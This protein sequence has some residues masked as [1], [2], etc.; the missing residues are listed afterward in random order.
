LPDRRAVLTSFRGL[1]TYVVPKVDVRWRDVAND[2][3]RNQANYVVSECHR[4]QRTRPLGRNLSSGN[5][6]VNLIPQ[7]TL[8]SDRRNNIDF[9]AAKILR[10]GQMHAV[11]STCHNIEQRCIGL[12][13]GLRG[14]DRDSG[15]RLT[16]S[17][18]PPRGS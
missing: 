15:E 11:G 16:P 1:A 12:Q 8:I 13:S 18:I 9:R 17:A 10:F 3:A 6:T 5:I 7:G 14:A 4:Q 2:Q